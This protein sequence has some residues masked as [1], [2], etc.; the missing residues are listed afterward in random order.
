MLP[1]RLVR[2]HAE[3][4]TGHSLKGDMVREGRRVSWNYIWLSVKIKYS[5]LGYRLVI[6]IQL[7]L[8]L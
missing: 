6:W 8:A 2:T 4:I 7:D 1:W 3:P 5:D